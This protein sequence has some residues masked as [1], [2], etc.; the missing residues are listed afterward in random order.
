[1]A[2]H[3]SNTLPWFDVAEETGAVVKYIELDEEGRMTL[4]NVKK[5]VTENT[6]DYFTCDCD[7]CIRL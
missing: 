3:A 4:E 7:K 6:K 5:V 1:M 2:E